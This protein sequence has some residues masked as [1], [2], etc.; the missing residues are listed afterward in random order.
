MASK[1]DAS[2]FSELVSTEGICENDSS[3]LS[4]YVAAETLV[5]V[6]STPALSLANEQQ[7][8]SWESASDYNHNKLITLWASFLLTSLLVGAV[9]YRRMRRGWVY[10]SEFSFSVHHGFKALSILCR[11]VS[12]R[13]SCLPL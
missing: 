12:I 5:S 7:T 3:I 2:S 9:G 4:S 13:R 6:H 10:V 1:L 11:S 8:A